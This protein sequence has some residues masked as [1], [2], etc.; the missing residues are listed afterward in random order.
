MERKW[1]KPLKANSLSQ[2]NKCVEVLPINNVVASQCLSSLGLDWDSQRYQK[3][4]GQGS[5]PRLLICPDH[6]KMLHLDPWAKETQ[7]LFSKF[8]KR[9]SRKGKRGY[10]ESRLRAW[11]GQGGTQV[12]PNVQVPGK[13]GSLLL[14]PLSQVT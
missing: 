13:G 14:P 3:Q 9:E 4:T 8:L 11:Q 1:N 10:G 2:G 6:N 7:L 5:A 12:T